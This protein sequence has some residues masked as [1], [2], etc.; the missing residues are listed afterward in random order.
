MARPLKH[1]KFKS[2]IQYIHNI[3]NMKTSMLKDSNKDSQSYR[4]QTKIFKYKLK[5]LLKFQK[6]VIPSYTFECE[7]IGQ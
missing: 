6:V 5:S 3:S 2:Y 1:M 7:L 4:N